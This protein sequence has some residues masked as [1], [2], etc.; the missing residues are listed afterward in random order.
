LEADDL[1]PVSL[2]LERP[3]LKAEPLA[4]TQKP[5]E[6]ILEGFHWERVPARGGCGRRG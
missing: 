6:E 4:L 1:A 5:S 2:E 3:A